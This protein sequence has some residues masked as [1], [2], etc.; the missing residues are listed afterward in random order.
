MLTRWKIILSGRVQGV[1]L[2][3][4]AKICAQKYHLTGWV[5]N[6]DDGDVEFE[7]QGE[8]AAVQA[9]VNEIR[10]LPGVHITFFHVDELK[11]IPETRFQIRQI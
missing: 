2:R 11:P 1:G 9:Y 6:L 3:F 10:T 4:R 5:Q 7:I 8:P